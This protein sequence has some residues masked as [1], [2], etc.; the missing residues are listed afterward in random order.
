MTTQ[1][2]NALIL[3]SVNQAVQ[4]AGRLSRDKPIKQQRTED[5][6]EDCA[7]DRTLVLAAAQ[8]AIAHHLRRCADGIERLTN[9]LDNR[10]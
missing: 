8:I 3:D 4:L 10:L 7:D 9:I 2:D 5:F 6:S 1:H